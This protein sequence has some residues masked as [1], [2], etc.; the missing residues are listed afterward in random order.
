MSTIMV[1][2]RPIQFTSIPHRFNVLAPYHSPAAKLYKCPADNVKTWMDSGQWLPGRLRSYAINH[3]VGTECEIFPPYHD[4]RPTL[5]VPGTYLDTEAGTHKR[6]KTWLT[7]GKFCDFRSPSDQFVFIDVGQ[8]Q[9]AP[10]QGTAFL[11]TMEESGW[12]SHPALHHNGGGTLSFSDG[13][14]SVRRW[15]DASTDCG[16]GA[17]GAWY[18]SVTKSRDWQWLSSKTSERIK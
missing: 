9:G 11:V 8:P 16:G 13:H 12:A 14:V 15:L 17:A 4:G 7:Y 18:Y 3:A 6:G 5:P 1:C 10:D 2:T